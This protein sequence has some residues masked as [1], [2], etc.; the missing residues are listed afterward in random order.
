VEAGRIR[1]ERFRGVHHPERAGC[2]RSTVP[3]GTG[4]RAKRSRS[5][6][7]ITRAYPFFS[8]FQKWSAASGD[9]PCLSRK[10]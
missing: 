10:I 8:H 3:P 4:T 7:G 6:R 2:V 1:A 9:L 5:W